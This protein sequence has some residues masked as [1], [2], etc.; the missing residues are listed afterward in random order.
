MFYFT[1]SSQKCL[2]CTG[3]KVSVQKPASGQVVSV[4]PRKLFHYE[5]FNIAL[6]AFPSQN[7]IIRMPASTSQVQ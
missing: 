6:V 5:Y 1:L 7:A 4:A 2:F 3:A